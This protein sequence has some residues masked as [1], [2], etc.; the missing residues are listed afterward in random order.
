MRR[1]KSLRIDVHHA[2]A[3]VWD[4]RLYPAAAHSVLSHLIY[5]REKGVVMATADNGLDCHY[6]IIES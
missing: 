2:D 5:L 3:V 6:K 1:E 4:K